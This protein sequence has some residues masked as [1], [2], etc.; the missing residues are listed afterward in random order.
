[1]RGIAYSTLLGLLWIADIPLSMLTFASPQVAEPNWFTTWT[2]V[3]RTA[4]LGVLCLEYMAVLFPRPR[5]A[6]QRTGA[7]V[8]AAGWLSVVPALTMMMNTYTRQT[9]EHDTATPAIDLIAQSQPGNKTIV[10][11]TVQL[12]RRLYPAA[13][14]VG[15]TWQLPLSKHVPEQERMQWVNNLTARGPFWF[16][17]DQGDPEDLDNNNGSDQWLSQQACKVDTQWG[18]SALVSRFVGRNGTPQPV[19]TS[20]LFGDQ[21]ELTGAQLYP[22][23]LRPGGTLCVDLNWRALK[24]P[25]GDYTVFVH[26]VDP[27]GQVVAQTDLQPQGGFSPT[28]QWTAGTPQIDRHGLILPDNLAAGDYTVRLGL[29]RSDDQSPLR[30]TRGENIMPDRSRRKSDNTEIGAM[31]NNGRSSSDRPFGLRL[32]FRFG[33]FSRGWCQSFRWR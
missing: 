15:E 9:L 13:R 6:F 31:N 17:A 28:S 32:T 25:D 33:C 12:Y 30:V 7:I 2:I 4:I 18:G 3:A 22:S 5:R 19:T 10:L 26:L 24:Q 20:A 11:A 16:M 23:T 8:M 27:N 14:L 29:Y 1:M 21:I